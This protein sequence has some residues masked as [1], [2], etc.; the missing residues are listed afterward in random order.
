MLDYFERNG[1]PCP[2]NT[3]PAEHIVDVVQGNTEEKIDWVEVWKRSEERQRAM[4]ELNA[5]NEACKADPNYIE[6]TADFA[7]SRWFQFKIVL[8]RLMIQL[9]RS[10]VSVPLRNVLL[11][12]SLAYSRL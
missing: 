8:N 9:W 7:T 6:D 3:N 4:A 11:A 2:P 5:L 10:P 1:A 12:D